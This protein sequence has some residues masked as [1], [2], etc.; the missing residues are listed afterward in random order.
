MLD[1]AL[2]YAKKNILHPI[3]NIYIIAPPNSKK[4]QAT[5]KKHK[6]TFIDETK[7]LDLKK[8]E[9]DYKVGTLNRNGWIYKMLIN[10]SADTVSKSRYILI[11]DAD[12][13]F[14][15]PQIFVYKERP[16][17]NLSNEYNQA[18]FDATERVIGLKHKPSRSF[19]THYMLFDAEAL[20]KLRAAIEE[21]WQKPWYKAIIDSIDKKERSGFADYEIY[22]DFYMDSMPKKPILNYWSNESLTIDSLADINAKIKSLSSSFRS[23]SFHNYQDE[24]RD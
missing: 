17:F 12:T 2:E 4:L 10:L 7:V 1:I 5:A 21:K 8:D 23:V 18:Y 6:A 14:I 15:A 9:I 11:L 13:C 20:R 22:G 19:I 3:K 24:L 16:L